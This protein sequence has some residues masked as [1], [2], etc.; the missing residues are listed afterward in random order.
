MSRAS[1]AMASAREARVDRARWGVA[2]RARGRASA[3]RPRATAGGGGRATLEIGS[4]GADVARLQQRLQDEG[5]V[6]VGTV[7]GYV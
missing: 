6:D 5:I 4:N 7:R 3:V 2:G 1:G